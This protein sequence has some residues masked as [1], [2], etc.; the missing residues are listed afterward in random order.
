MAVV[1]LFT[2]RHLQTDAQRTDDITLLITIVNKGMYHAY[3]TTAL[4]E[5]EAHHE[6]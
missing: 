3:L 4:I 5:I 6:G 2:H 1:C